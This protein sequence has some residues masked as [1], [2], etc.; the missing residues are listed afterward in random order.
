MENPVFINPKSDE[1]LIA[2]LLDL[3]RIEISNVQNFFLIQELQGLVLFNNIEVKNKGTFLQKVYLDVLLEPLILFFM[4]NFSDCK[5]SL[6]SALVLAILDRGCGVA[7][8]K[9]I[10]VVKNEIGPEA[11]NSSNENK[12]FLFIST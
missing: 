9:P 8:V 12:G 2:V 11:S 1:R 3:D 10:P 5:R 6:A 4:L 7:E